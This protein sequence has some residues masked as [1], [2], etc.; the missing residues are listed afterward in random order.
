MHLPRMSRVHSK[1]TG[2]MVAQSARELYEYILY[3]THSTF[4]RPG[5]KPLAFSKSVEPNGSTS[6]YRMCKTQYISTKRQLLQISELF[7]E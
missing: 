3:G 1:C 7:Y 4:S 6:K 2:L 5:E